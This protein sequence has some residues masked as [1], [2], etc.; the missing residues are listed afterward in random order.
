MDVESIRRSFVEAVEYRQARDEY[1][2]SDWDFFQSLSYAVRDRMLD[3]WNQTQQRHYK[4]DKRRVYYISLEFLIGRLLRNALL[5]LGIFDEAKA[6][7]ATFGLDIEDLLNEEV[8]AGLGNGGLGRL[9]ACFLDSMATLGLPAMGYGIRYEYGMFEQRIAAS[10]QVE[11]P[12][13]WL[14]FDSPWDIA[15]PNFMLPVRFYG[16]VVSRMDAEGNV[17]FDW[18]DTEEVMA[19]AHDF[20][21]PGF[22]NDACNTLRLWAA[23]ASN[24]FDFANFNRG[25]YVRAVHD[26]TA[27]ENISW[28]LYPNDNVAQ[29]KELRLK[30]EYFLVSATLQDAIRRHLKTNPSAANLHEK[31]VFQ[32]NDTHPTLAIPELMRLLMDEHGLSWDVAWHTTRNAMAYTNHTILPEALE[33]WNVSLFERLLPRHL[34]IIYE[35]NFRFLKEVQQRFPGDDHRVR[36]MSIINEDGERSVRMAH[37]A[38][39]GSYSVN[40]VSALHS[41]LVQERLFPD[42][43]AMHSD[44]FNNKTNGVTPRRWIAGCNPALAKLVTKSIGDEWV[45]DLN[46]ISE[47]EAFAQNGN[48]GK[49]WRVAKNDCKKRLVHWI[50]KEQGIEID[51][52]T[53][54]DVQVKRIHEYKRQ[55]LNVFHVL[56]RYLSLKKGIGI[57][58]PAR[59][60]FIG[61]KAA[62]GYDTAKSIIHLINATGQLINNDPDTKH[63][64][65]LVF[66]PNYNVSVA[67]LVIPAADLSEQIST[68]GLEASGT[69]N[70]KFA[71]NGA[72]TIG[73]RD[74]A[75]IEIGEAV[76]EENIYFFGLSREGVDE[77]FQRGYN[78][79]AM[80]TASPRLREVL[81]FISSGVLS[82]RDKGA[83]APIFSSL[84]SHG[85]RFLVLADFDAYIDCQARVDAD[86]VDTKKWT[87]MSILN[88]ARNGHFSSDRTIAAYAEEIWRTEPV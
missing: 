64:L 26:K 82:P 6:A 41:D 40:G 31:A 12:N 52:N 33:Q 3:R 65:R 63:L 17:R 59:T 47:I 51:V 76:G 42:F 45:R 83:F 5:N 54:F 21:V 4:A 81:D 62:P 34:Q 23:K 48:F 29:G 30:Q 36:R 22:K 7:M 37:L 49:S 69:G 38:V 39:V 18:V 28:V 10:Q 71:M 77:I 46:R 25:D 11:V 78:P 68:A 80:V 27:S 56:H 24:A 87:T 55:L 86:F 2:V 44:R 74:G 60:V 67:E 32:L 19:V 15:R 57:D 9:A 79:Q 43:A 84:F 16:R 66:V 8:D 13:N 75:N 61:G 1:S 14:R 73:T 72:L 50:K 35:I 85:D 53:M 20:L 58:R 88:T 70:M